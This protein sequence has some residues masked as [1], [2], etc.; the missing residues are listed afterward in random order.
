MSEEV[1]PTYN[2]EQNAIDLFELEDDMYVT[3]KYC[4]FKYEGDC[5]W[6]WYE[7]IFN[8]QIFKVVKNDEKL[9]NYA[10]DSADTG[11]RRLHHI[12]GRHYNGCCLKI[13]DFLL[14]QK[15]FEENNN[16][17]IMIGDREVDSDDALEGSFSNHEDLFVITYFEPTIYK[18]SDD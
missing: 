16:T 6:R 7:P 14:I 17:A 1:P 18:D 15:L 12:L 10:D 5:N 13:R 4:Y 9:L 2:E 3:I 11:D 8:E